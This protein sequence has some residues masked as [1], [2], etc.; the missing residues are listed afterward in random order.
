MDAWSEGCGDRCAVRHATSAQ[1]A[2]DVPLLAEGDGARLPVANDFATKV[3]LRLAVVGAVE[4]F[5]E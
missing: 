2:L 5:Q 4:G 3:V 1:H